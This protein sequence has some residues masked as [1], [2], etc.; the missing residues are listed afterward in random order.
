MKN[1]QHNITLKEVAKKA[2]VS[3][4]AVSRAFTEGASVS[5]KTRKK[6]EDVARELNY[7]PNFLARSLT[8]KRTKLI[9]LISDNYSNPVF[10]DI[11]DLFT[12][13]LQDRGFRPL[14]YNY[15]HEK[16]IENAIR[17]LRQYNVDAVIIASS[18]ISEKFVKG[19]KQMGC[20]V[21]HTFGH[22]DSNSSINVVA[23]DN[24]HGGTL[25]AKALLK[26]NHRHIVFLG[27]PEKATSTQDRLKGF[28]ETLAKENVSVA[29]TLFCK[30]YSYDSGKYHMTQFLKQQSLENIDAVFCGDDLICIGAIDA[31]YEHGYKI[32]DDVGFI[33]FNDIY[34]G[35][36]GRFKLTTIHQPIKEITLN[37]VDLIL[38][39]LE[40]PNQYTQ[41]RLFPCKLVERDTL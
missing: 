11:F 27:G 31:A 40:K 32:P 35:H 30:H 21:V 9:A 17:M 22:Y 19:L 7:S 12:K 16:N 26:K 23:P 8:T 14:L 41:T 10:L 1:K 28:T 13:T 29:Y 36:W 5:Q 15:S 37:S 25:A 4:S 2:G 20:P 24:I 3:T 33:G 34:I 18:T 6:I 39:L 38:T